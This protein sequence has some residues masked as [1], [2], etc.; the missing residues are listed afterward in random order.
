MRFL[1]ARV[2]QLAEHVT[3]GGSV[4]NTLEKQGSS[5]IRVVLIRSTINHGV[6]VSSTATRT[7]QRLIFTEIREDENH[8][9]Q[10]VGSKQTPMRR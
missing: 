1:C 6:A 7:K 2:A 8:S 9:R 5:D 4:K 10:D 3:W